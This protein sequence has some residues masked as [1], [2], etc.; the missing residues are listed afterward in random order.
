MFFDVIQEID[1][2]EFDP[3]RTVELCKRHYGF[4]VGE[5]GEFLPSATLKGLRKIFGNNITPYQIS[6]SAYSVDIKC[7]ICGQRNV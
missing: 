4:F 6:S 7:E 1:V 3:A 5:D 2:G